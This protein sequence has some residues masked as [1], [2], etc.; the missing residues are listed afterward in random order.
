LAETDGIPL[1]TGDE[2]LYNAVKKDLKW[3]KWIAE[4]GAEKSALG[5]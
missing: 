4:K 1:I 5:S 3:V 2:G